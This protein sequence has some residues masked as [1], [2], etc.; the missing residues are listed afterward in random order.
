MK[1]GFFTAALPTNTL[2]QAAQWGAESGFQAIE[3]ACWPLEKATRRYAGVTHINVTEL[4]KT[5]AKQIRKMLDDY[6]LTISSLGY[7][8]NPL[9]PDVEHRNTVIAHLKKV[10]EAAALL[11]VPIVGTFIG[12]D[13]NKTVPQNLEEYAKIWPPIV[14]FAQEHNVKIAI[15]NCPMIFS[16]DEWPGGN[17]LA[18]TPAIWRKM[19]EIIPDDN[20]G[21]NLDPSHLILQ[22]IDYERVVHEFASKIFHVHA[23]D[24]HIDREGLYN[25][26]VLSQ[27]MGWQ[28][29]R[30]PGL[31]DMD[32]G[33][34][35][36]ALTAVGYDYVV[37]IEH[38]DR[39]FE[40]DEN[41][42]KRGF[43]LSRD[44]LK[45]YFH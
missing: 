21:L 37:S 16:Y 41:L 34:F 7:Y 24:L 13:K 40:G 39:A 19:W 9:H 35:F 29:P 25:H 10:I 38:E 26:G 36:A 32:W 42:V 1:L 5:Q 27:G 3:I 11:E 33:K 22:M 20:F 31:G 43:Y 23:K 6:G 17:N 14:K 12:K 8:P 44:L 30:L 2:E 45:P 18:S 15:E 28:V 4:N